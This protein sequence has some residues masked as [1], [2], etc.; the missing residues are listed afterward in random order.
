MEKHQERGESLS[1]SEQPSS[2]TPT[3]SQKVEP[4][5]LDNQQGVF[6]FFEQAS[7]RTQQ[8]VT[9]CTAGLISSVAV[10]AVSQLSTKTVLQPGITALSQLIEIGFISLVTAVVVGVT[11]FALGLI[12]TNQINRGIDD[13]QTQLNAVACGDLSVQATVYSPK[14]W[15][16]LATSF[17]QMT[18]ELYA[19][20][21]QSQQKPKEQE[22]ATED[23]PGL[24]TKLQHEPEFSVQGGVTVEPEVAINE[25][26]P[27]FL[28]LRDSLVDFL[29]N[30]QS[31]FQPSSDF[32]LSS[33]SSSR[34]EIEQYKGQLEYRSAQLKALLHEIDRELVFIA[35]SFESTIE[36]RDK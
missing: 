17:N 23:L 15:R 28:V 20:L 35:E 8:L 9:A 26:D 31:G 32:I 13:L 22:K 36:V 18:L 2:F 16:E 11:T 1:I 3:E 6:A 7:L 29:D 10:I 21:S 24:M 14:E 33:T 34:E 5:P 30:I 12:T 19:M 27:K 4:A 25:Q